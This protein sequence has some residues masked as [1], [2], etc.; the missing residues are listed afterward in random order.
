MTVGAPDRTGKTQEALGLLLCF[1][2]AHFC[3]VWWDW[4]VN[5]SFVF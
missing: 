4:K 3:S 2:E 1:S 5:V